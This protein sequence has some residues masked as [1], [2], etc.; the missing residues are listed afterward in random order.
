MSRAQQVIVDIGLVL[1]AA[2]TLGVLVRRRY[3]LWW[4]FALYLIA[5]TIST[6]LQALWPNQFVNFEFWQAKETVYA[7]LRFAMACEVGVRTLRAFPGAFAAARRLILLVLLVTLM[8][9][10]LAPH[11]GE[12]AGFVG[13]LVPRVLN[14][15]AWMLMTIGAV[16]L[17]YRIPVHPFHKAVLL[18]YIP[19][20]LVFTVVTKRIAVFPTEAMQYLNQLA[21]VALLAYWNYVIWRRDPRAALPHRPSAAIGAA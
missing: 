6:T 11:G 15:S 8:A 19:Y 16:I 5:V 9:V 21:Y 18:S 1:V 7:V 14:G 17:W 20:V 12:L 10:A 3:R 2:A 4:S 13:E